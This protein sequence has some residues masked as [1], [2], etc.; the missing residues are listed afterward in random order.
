MLAADGTQRTET[1]MTLTLESTS[2]THGG[3]IPDRHTCDGADT[4]PPLAWHGVPAETRSL[5][6]IVDD[7]D[8][9]DPD[10][11]RM[12]WVHWVIYNLPP[13]TAGLPEGCRRTDLP[14]GTRE[15]VNSWNRTGYGG[16]CP[17]V[18]RHRYFHRL[19]ALD[20]ILPDLHAPTAEA[21]AAAMDGHV[22]AHAELL[23]TYRRSA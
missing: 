10:A 7:P 4:A 6:L 21:L 13:G 14:D 20:T 12:T 1:G 23:G 22:I 5:A 11:P 16:P 17:P 2:F 8:A 3:A 9:P 18:G 15:G 19:Y